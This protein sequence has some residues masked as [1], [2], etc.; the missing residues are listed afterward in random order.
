[1]ASLH[2]FNTWTFSNWGNSERHLE[3]LPLRVGILAFRCFQGGHHV[4][5]VLL[6]TLIELFMRLCCRILWHTLQLFQ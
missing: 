1:M 5:R 6:H 3:F 2:S 4:W